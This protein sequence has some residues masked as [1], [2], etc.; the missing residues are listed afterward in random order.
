MVERLMSSFAD[1]ESNLKEQFAK[2]KKMRAVNLQQRIAAR[3][4]VRQAN[5]LTKAK[6]FEGIDA[7]TTDKI[8]KKMAYER[9]EE[10]DHLCEQGEK[11]DRFFVLVSGTCAVKQDGNQVGVLEALDIMG[12]NALSGG[13]RSAT[14][15]ATSVVQTLELTSD[16]FGELVEQGIIAKEVLVRV[17]DVQKE[18][19][20]ICQSLRQSKALQCTDLF[21]DLDEEADGDCSDGT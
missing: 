16:A 9:Y 18:R 2:T 7:D 14:V 8:L 6:V 11:A 19:E 21:Q 5:A 20:D 1:S 10:G 15:T 13:T 17:R 12:E 3:S 4:K